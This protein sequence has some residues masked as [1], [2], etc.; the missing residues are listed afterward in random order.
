MQFRRKTMLDGHDTE[1]AKALLRDSNLTFLQIADRLNCK[2][3]VIS[4]IN[5]E[6]GPIRT[7]KSVQTGQ[8][9]KRRLLRRTKTLDPNRSFL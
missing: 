6:N 5:R 4:D 3:K 1:R 2:E 8:S 7:P 9:I